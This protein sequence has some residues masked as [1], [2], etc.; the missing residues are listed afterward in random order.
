MGGALA[1]ENDDISADLDLADLDG[2]GFAAGAFVKRQAGPWLFA[3]GVSAGKTSYDSRRR[4]TIGDLTY[5]NKASPDLTYVGVHARVA[6]DMPR[7]G[8]S[9]FG[10]RPGST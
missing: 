4:I 3:A 5:E 2:E 7:E 9:I 8:S 10:P 6:Y 1:Y